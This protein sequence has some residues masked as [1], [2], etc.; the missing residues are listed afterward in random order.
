[1]FVPERFT[2][3]LTQTEKPRE[4][5][6]CFAGIAWKLLLITE[7]LTDFFANAV[8][9]QVVFPRAIDKA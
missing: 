4:T 5:P 8:Y 2:A 3:C 6:G 7:N 1:M 9:I